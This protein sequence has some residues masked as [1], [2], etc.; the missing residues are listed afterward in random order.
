MTGRRTARPDDGDALAERVRR[1]VDAAPPPD[2]ATL[3]WLHDLLGDPAAWHAAARKAAARKAASRRPR[4]D[5][6]S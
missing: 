3:A 1:I 2:E 6:A 4:H 5:G